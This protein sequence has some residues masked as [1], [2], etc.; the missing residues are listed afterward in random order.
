MMSPY[1]RFASSAYHS[2][3]PAAYFTSPR[4]SVMGLPI[5]CVIIFASV[6]SSA[7]MSSY[8]LRRTADRSNA[9]FDF[10]DTKA[11]TDLSIA[12]F[13]SSTE[14]SGARSRTALVAGLMTSKVAIIPL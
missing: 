3:K 12:S 9:V 1:A 2:T 5:S 4:D 7:R 13:A 6:A 10:H 8:H 14:A 11:A